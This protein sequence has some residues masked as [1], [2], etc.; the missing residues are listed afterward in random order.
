MPS[1]QPALGQEQ[2][3]RSR[4]RRSKRSGLETNCVRTGEKMINY[5][6]GIARALSTH[7]EHGAL[8]RAVSTQRGECFGVDR[9]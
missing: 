4:A 5:M 6:V 9:S 1:S 8:G 3:C 7:A 2:P